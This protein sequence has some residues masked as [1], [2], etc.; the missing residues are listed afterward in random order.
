MVIRSIGVAKGDVQLIARSYDV[1]SLQGVLLVPRLFSFLSLNQHF[2]TL[3]QCL[4]R[5]AVDFTRF[6]VLIIALFAGFLVTFAV[7][8]R[9]NYTVEDVSWMLVRIFFGNS[10]LAFDSMRIIDPVFGPPLMLI[11]VIFSQILLTT[12]LISILSNSFA[13]V[14]SNS[15]EEY[16]FL[17]ATTCLE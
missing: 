3:F 16:L 12:V 8:G 13:Q 7:L 9:Q 15:R 2:A 4:R 6:L 10:F 1:L 17:F 11:F 5:L 14:M